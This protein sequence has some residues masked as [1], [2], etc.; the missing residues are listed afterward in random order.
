MGSWFNTEIVE[1]GRLPLFCF[2]S[3]FIATFGFIRFSVRMIR[4]Q[5]RWWPGNVQPGGLHIHHVV[6]G[7]VLMVVSGVAVF[8]VHD[9]SPGVKSSLAAA[10]GVGTALV[11]DEFALILHL[12]DVYWQEAGRLSIDAIFV[13]VAMV[14]LVLLGFQPLGVVDWN[15]YREAPSP[16]TAVAVAGY[17]LVQLGLAVITLLKGKVWTG[18][19]GLFLNPLLIVGAW[20]LGRPHSPWSRWRYPRRPR[21]YERAVRR[22]ERW[23]SPIVGFKVTFQELLS[24]RHDARAEPDEREHV[25]GDLREQVRGD[26]R[27]QVRGDLRE[28]V[29][30]ARTGDE[31]PPRPEG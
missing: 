26:L 24:G 17:L 13:A 25:R 14:G 20:R 5:V 22:E 31:A 23:H 3:A 1:L 2:L 18:L 19:L 7:V 21:K 11:L 6:F 12:R 28:D 10:F 27:E 8:A 16:E 9:P 30:G 29:R 4:A 15:D